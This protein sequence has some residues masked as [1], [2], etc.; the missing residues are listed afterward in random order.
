MRS[1]MLLSRVTACTLEEEAKKR[2]KQRGAGACCKRWRGTGAGGA[3]R[4]GTQEK[5]RLGRVLARVSHRLPEAIA[6]AAAGMLRAKVRNTGPHGRR[7]DTNIG[8]PGNVHALSTHVQ[9]RGRKGER[10][11]DGQGGGTEPADRAKRAADPAAWP[12]IG[13]DDVPRGDSAVGGT[14]VSSA[15]NRVGTDDGWSPWPGDAATPGD[16]DRLVGRTP[17]ARTC[18]VAVPT[19]SR[20][21]PRARAQ[22]YG[23]R[24]ASGDASPD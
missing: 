5:E 19:D 23:E 6:P 8:G 18:P 22:R 2:C 11:E 9:S 17:G 12:T 1:H 3:R 16:A 14:W 10:G 7:V 15:A 24:P 20:L 21:A 4:E 13:D